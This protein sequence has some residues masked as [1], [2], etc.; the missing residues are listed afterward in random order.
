MPIACFLNI[1]TSSP[2][3]ATISRIQLYID[4]LAR[5][6]IV[7]SPLTKN[8]SNIIRS[9]VLRWDLCCDS[10]GVGL[11]LTRHLISS[12]R[13]T[14][15]LVLES[16]RSCFY[17]WVCILSCNCVIGSEPCNLDIHGVSDQRN[18]ILNPKLGNISWKCLV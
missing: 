16:G 3:A 18:A 7:R 9:S 12:R 10:E 13:S 5:L 1:S 17:M 4:S 6:T 15:V 11:V 2:I 14:H 8:C